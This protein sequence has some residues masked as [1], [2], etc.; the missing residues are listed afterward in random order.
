M[1]QTL[2]RVALVTGASRGIGRSIS[3][4]LCEQV[5]EIYLNHR[6]N[7]SLVNDLVL[8]IQSKTK[9]KATAIAFDVS[10]EQSVLDAFALIEKQSGGV[11]VLVNNAGISIDALLLRSKTQDFQS[12][13]N[14]N[15]LGAFLCTKAAIK[16]MMKRNNDGRIIYISSVVGQM[17]NAGQ[18]MYAASKAGLIGFAKS[19]ARELASRQITVNTVAPGFIKTDMTDTLNEKQKEALLKTIPL[20][21]YGEPEEIAGVVEF[22]ASRQSSYMTGQ[23]IGVNGGMYL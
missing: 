10:N 14:V 21:R 11:D 6:S 15:L 2:S 23:V 9:T 3:L 13:F 1:T 22:L 5:D 20:G 4:A 12:I 19:M 17:G 8:E 7:E 16:S 18:A